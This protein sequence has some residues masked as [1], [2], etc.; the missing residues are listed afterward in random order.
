MALARH[1]AFDH[2]SG[3]RGA[4][5]DALRIAR[6]VVRQH[7]WSPEVRINAANVA[8]AVD[9]DPSA[10][11]LIDEHLRLFPNDPLALSTAAVLAVRAGRDGEAETFARKALAI[12]P[13][14]GTARDVLRDVRRPPRR[15]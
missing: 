1:Q 4:K 14:S 8:S 9:D 13:E 5:S 12:D 7:E 2:R 6:R 3:E 11:S 10:Q 15:E